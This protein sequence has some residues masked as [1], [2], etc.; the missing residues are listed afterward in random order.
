LQD[1]S[2]QACVT[3]WEQRAARV[4]RVLRLESI[5]GKILVF[6]VFA[7]LIPSLATA[8]ISYVQNQR[9]L[10]EKIAENLQGA[11]SQ[12]AREVD[13]WLKERLYDLRVFASSYEVS[14]NLERLARARGAAARPR[15]PLARLTDYLNSVRERFSDFEELSVLDAPG[16]LVV[17][18]GRGGPPRPVPPEWLTELRTGDAV[19]G[20]AFWD[21]TVNRA[22]TLAAVPIHGAGGRFV[23]ALTARL[24]L[25]AVDAILARFSPA[26]A[27]RIYVVT[28]DGTLVTGPRGG[29]A[30]P[31]RTRLP[32]D[33][34]RALFGQEAA[35][36]TYT[37]VEGVEVVGVMQRV[38][39]LPWVVIAE[40][41]RAEAYRQVIRLRDVT[42]VVLAALVLG[43]GSIAYLL[44]LL[45]LRPIDRLRLGAAKVAAGDLDVDL[46]V[47]SGGEVGYLTEVFNDMVTRLREG[48]R[49]LEHLSVTDGLTGLYNRRHLME[50]LNEEVNRAHRH[51]RGFAVLMADIDHFKQYNDTYG[52]LA[53]DKVLVRVAEILREAIRNVD[54][55]A[56]YGGEEFFVM[57]PETALE[58][59]AE[60]ADRIRGRLAGQIIA[61]GRVTISVGVAEF[62]IHGDTPE[63]LI[64]TAD[65][66][67]YEA[68]REGRNRVLRARRAEG[69]T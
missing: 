12:A 39:R 54:Y 18:S 47:V 64:A 9:A 17:R 14:E 37:G 57:M 62:P 61:G 23:G 51:G 29:P 52:H 11:S 44:S 28:G 65:A 3:S 33:A 56:R 20:E 34:A 31:L 49:D 22:A 7:T 38:P 27:G 24:N 59:A 41:P 43:L 25:G 5:R 13:L 10:T 45:I 2:T 8:W 21:E 58:G 15:P 35:V 46:P 16:R 60:V 19:L 67:L 26:P 48:R 30:V 42:I 66:A 40:V 55:A 4:L 6:A 69:R 32:P 53:G 63:A 1:P 36:V 50:T 68:K